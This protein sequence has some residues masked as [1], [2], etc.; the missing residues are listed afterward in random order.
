MENLDWEAAHNY[1]NMLIAE[2]VMLSPVGK[3]GLSLMLLLKK[4]FDDGE[5]TTKLYDEIMACS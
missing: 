4:R 3:F 5:R 1:L 2:Y